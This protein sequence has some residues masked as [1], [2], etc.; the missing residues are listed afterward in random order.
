MSFNLRVNWVIRIV[1]AIEVSLA[2][3]VSDI[4][5]ECFEKPVPKTL[6]WRV[7]NAAKM[8]GGRKPSRVD[9]RGISRPAVNIELNKSASWIQISDSADTLRPV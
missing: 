3:E 4:E 7:M 5:S 1:N 9:I 6:N 8:L 2:D